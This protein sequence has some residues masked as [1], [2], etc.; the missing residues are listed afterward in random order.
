M[1]TEDRTGPSGHRSSGS[2][3]SAGSARTVNMGGS[4]YRYRGV[5]QP[6][7][8]IM[9][10]ADGFKT[11]IKDLETR[12][13]SNGEYGLVNGFSIDFQGAD[14]SLVHNVIWIVEA[15]RRTGYR[16][17]EGWE[18]IRFHLYKQEQAADAVQIPA[19]E[20]YLGK[21]LKGAFTSKGPDTDEVNTQL[22]FAIGTVESWAK[23]EKEREKAK[24]TKLES[25]RCE[26]ER[27]LDQVRE[28]WLPPP[29]VTDDQTEYHRYRAEMSRWRNAR[30]IIK[31]ERR[32]VKEVVEA[33]RLPTT[34]EDNPI[35]DCLAQTVEHTKA[36]CAVAQDELRDMELDRDVRA[37]CLAQTVEH[38]GAVVAQD[39]SRELVMPLVVRATSENICTVK[40]VQ[41]A[42]EDNPIVDWL[43]QT[44]GHAGVAENGSDD[45]KE[46]SD[47]D[48][49]RDEDF[50]WGHH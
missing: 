28:G 29:P 43:A 37:K 18:G 8:A 1:N 36:A 3:V 7:E 19:A 16:V 21:D 48:M 2:S 30:M 25:I 24:K 11:K 35:V 9:D 33:P 13:Q 10:S 27:Y 15:L 50:Y 20:L 44:I 45:E 39:E 49:R 23:L 32:S 46:D 12:V 5:P 47:D 34:D 41:T 38:A 31:E 40:E 22:S 6:R 4:K 42:D 14:S 17:K 26:Q